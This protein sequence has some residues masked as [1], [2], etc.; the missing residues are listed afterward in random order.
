MRLPR[1][2]LHVFLITT[3]ALWFLP[4]AWAV[5][6]SLRPYADTNSCGYVSL[7]GR[8][9]FHNYT[10][11]DDFDFNMTSPLGRMVLNPDVTVRSRGVMEKCSLCVRRVQLAKNTAL[12]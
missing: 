7:C 6:T 3:A 1:I 2:G 10:D 8:F 5:F 12:K 11:N 9:N 4:V